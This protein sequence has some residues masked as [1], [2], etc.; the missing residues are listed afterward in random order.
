M[1]G[2]QKS[3]KLSGEYETSDGAVFQFDFR[4]PSTDAQAVKEFLEPQLRAASDKTL[5]A[6]FELRMDNGLTMSGDAPE[7]LS[8]RLTR[9]AA[10]SAYV[11][12]SA[13]AASATKAGAVA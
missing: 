10:G 7:R 9:H 6:E 1:P 3:A 13:E 11:T 8:E 4:G 2:A 5:N 12:A